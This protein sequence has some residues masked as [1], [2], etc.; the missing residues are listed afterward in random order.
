MVGIKKIKEK[1]YLLL[2]GQE[3]RYMLDAIFDRYTS[4]VPVL[5]DNLCSLFYDKPSCQGPFSL[6]WRITYGCNCNCSFCIQHGFEGND[7]NTKQANDVALQIARS[8]VCVVVLSGGKPFIR[9]DI[10]NIIKTLRKYNKYVYIE[11]NELL[12]ETFCDKIISLGI[13]QLMIS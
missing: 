5:L 1:I 6:L 8:N 4:R 13:E 11:T 3:N 9:K 12:L 2:R 7:L 10:F